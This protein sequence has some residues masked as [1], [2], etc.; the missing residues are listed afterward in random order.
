MWGKLWEVNKR[1]KSRIR[2][3]EMDYWRDN[4]VDELVSIELRMCNKGNG[5]YRRRNGNGRGGNVKL[6]I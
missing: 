5:D 1:N 6:D 4:T 3:V 2:A